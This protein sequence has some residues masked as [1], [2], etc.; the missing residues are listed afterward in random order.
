[1]QKFRCVI[2]T[3]EAEVVNTEVDSV[4]LTTEVGDLML[5]P[6]H[7]ALSGSITYSSVV[8]RMDEK[9][10]EYLAYSGVVFFSNQRNEAHILCQRADLKDRVDYGGLQ[11]YLKLVQD[12]IENGKDLS[13]IHMKYLEGERLALFEG[14]EAKEA[15]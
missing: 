14:M 12:R 4:Y 13:D 11:S 2:R 15:K 6:G 1:M 5:M 10:E 9:Q 8:L 7:S 3:P